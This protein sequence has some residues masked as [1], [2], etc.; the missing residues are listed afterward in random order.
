MTWCLLMVLL[1]LLHPAAKVDAFSTT[2]ITTTRKRC[3]QPTSPFDSKKNLLT[4]FA[5]ATQNDNQQQQQSS[6]AS[7]SSFWGDSTA[8]KDKNNPR[9]DESTLATDASFASSSAATAFA[10][11]TANVTYDFWQDGLTAQNFNMDLANLAAHDPQQAQDALEIMYELHQQQQGKDDKQQ[12]PQPQPLVTIEPDARCYATV[13]DG[14]VQAGMPAAAQAVLDIMEE[15]LLSS[16]NSNNNTTTTNWSHPMEQAYLLVA[17]AWA[18]DTRG[19]FM[20]TSADQAEQLLLRSAQSSA[21]PPNVKLWSI[22]VE[23]W[24]KRTGITRMALARADALL[25]EMEDDVDLGSVATMQDEQENETAEEAAGE[26][27]AAEEEEKATEKSRVN[28]NSPVTSTTTATAT[29]SLSTSTVPPTSPSSSSRSAKR[30]A[31][32]SNT[33]AWT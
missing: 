31:R 24:C 6:S 32:E 2:T 23:G 29:S 15:R 10:M 3:L 5:R 33:P 22:V 8:D 21:Q 20:G 9:V 7:S 25:S 16:R 26:E 30:P 17:Q 4:L 14:Y 1:L 28:A 11:A 27:E 18:D 13:I 19:D 12:Q